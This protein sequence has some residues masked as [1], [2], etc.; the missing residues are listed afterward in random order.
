MIARKTAKVTSHVEKTT[1]K[2]SGLK[3]TTTAA[4]ILVSF[5]D[6]AWF[7]YLLRVLRK[8]FKIPNADSGPEEGI[9]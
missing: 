3:M 5:L 6:I 8:T 2:E 9:P 1:A 7:W 4:L